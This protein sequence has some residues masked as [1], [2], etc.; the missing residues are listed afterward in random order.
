M[1]KDIYAKKA[2]SQIPRILS[3]ED[4]N[5]FSPTYGCFNREFWLNKTLDFPSAIA[6]FATH[7]LA[8]VYSFKFPQ[9]IF[10]K[11]P[12]I[13]KWT[14]AGVDFWTKIQKNDGSFDE[15][16][17]NERG[18]AGPTGFLLYAMVETYNL[19]KEHFPA[20]LKSRFFKTVYKAAR[21]LMLHDESGVLANHHAIALLAIWKA[22]LLLKDDDI[23]KGFY[24]RQEDFFKYCYEEGWSLEY[25]GPDLGYLSASISFLGKLYK[26]YK[27]K[28]IF[29][30]LQKKIE[31]SS[32][33]VYPDGFYAGSIGS[34]H[35]LHFYAHGYE[36]MGKE[37]PLAFS[38]A[39][40]MLQ[41][42]KQ[43]KLVPPEIQED[44]YFIY[45][46]A[47]F[48]EAYLDF[49]PRPKDLPKLPYERQPFQIYFKKANILVNQ[50]KNHYLV[51]NLAKGGVIKL[52]SLNPKKLILNDCGLIVMLEDGRVA[53]TQWIEGYKVTHNQEFQVKGRFHF[54][55]YPL[56]TPL[57]MIGFRL[58]MLGLGWH[59]R[60]A[61]ELKGLI[62]RVLML[63]QKK[64]PIGFKRKIKINK[65]IISIQD[66]LELLSNINLT[67]MSIGDEFSVRY[68]PQSRYFQSMEL[69]VQGVSLDHPTISKLNKNRRICIQRSIDI[70]NKKQDIKITFKKPREYIFSR[71]SNRALCYRLQRRT[72]EVVRTIKNH[73]SEFKLLLDIGTA[74]G[75]MLEYLAK[76]FPQARL[77][78]LEKERGYIEEKEPNLAILQGKG[79]ELPFKSNYFDVV[80]STAV[81]EHLKR[82]KEMIKEVFRILKNQGI[83]VLTT[84]D[85]F[86]EKLASSLGHLGKDI[87]EH[88]FNLKELQNMLCSCGF[89]ILEAQ[90]FM[91][92]P[93]GFPFEI[94]I[95]EFL[96]KNK[97]SLLLANQIVVAQKET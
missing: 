37:I 15:F 53:T 61:Y 28:K 27:S 82:P 6:Q 95:E 36:I 70:S 40:K 68:V 76:E 34:R 97:L 83:F 50:S 12:K 67:K 25:D 85:P 90:K 41:A 59:T 56:F 29:Q 2:I 96:K 39:D 71:E 20:E 33:F 31:F 8:L 30:L 35:T 14:L 78:G 89:K 43:G 46:T 32:Y 77:L 94:K 21:F 80:I 11:K 1:S 93:V 63:K 55:R 38:I 9:N 60:L 92:S 65:D 22:Y 47:E 91:L 75:K 17:P 7:S 52:F 87:H 42:L 49:Q 81:I 3:L 74:E 86:W 73:K 66:E 62:R 44:R 64:A 54:I 19:L 13:L 84:P 18:W 23:L 24:V 45:R 72:K 4:R 26:V 48:L 10:Y 5:E 79:E 88:T 69:E 16:Y 58:A 57:K 51:V